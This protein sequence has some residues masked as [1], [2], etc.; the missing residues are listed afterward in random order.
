VDVAGG[1]QSYGRAVERSRSAALGIAFAAAL[2]CGGGPQLN[3][4]QVQI[5]QHA[6]FYLPTR[7]SL[8][9]GVLD[10]QQKFGLTLG[11]RL[12]LTFNPRFN[13]VTAVNY[14]PG[15]A[16]LRAAGQRVDLA[17]GSHLLTATL[18]AMYWLIPPG[19]MFAWEVH[20]G[21]GL[22]SGGESFEELFQGSTLSGVL[23]TMV[24]CEIGRLVSLRMR[25]Q[26]RLYRFR[27]GSDESPSS[28]KPLRVTLGV[29]FPLLQSLLRPPPTE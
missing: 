2:V 28:S 14:I 15:Y 27:L 9:N 7:L 6:R 11:A 12:K 22:A 5:R 29:A 24:R 16:V 4:Q 20:S 13:L 18:G 21:V 19:K 8:Q 17:T 10:L 26:E 1:A 25:I 3:A 23:G